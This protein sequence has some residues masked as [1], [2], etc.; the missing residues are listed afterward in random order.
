MELVDLYDEDRLPLGRTAERYGEHLPGEHRLVVHVCLFD[1]SG[2]L[3]TPAAIPGEAAVAG[4]VG[5]LSERRC[6]G[7]RD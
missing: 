4:A 5:R 7:G 3:L 6:G 1:R 2:R